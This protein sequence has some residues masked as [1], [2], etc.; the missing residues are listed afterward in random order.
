LKNKEGMIMSIE[1]ELRNTVTKLLND[2]GLSP[3]NREWQAIWELNER[4]INLVYCLSY[5]ENIRER[6]RQYKRSI[7]KEHDYYDWTQ[8]ITRAIEYFE[9]EIAEIDRFINDCKA[10]VEVKRFLE[11]KDKGNI[12]EFGKH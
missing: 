9:S 1:E 5:F 3:T 10:V 2:L 6:F 11:Q 4:K 12:I 8:S 7:N